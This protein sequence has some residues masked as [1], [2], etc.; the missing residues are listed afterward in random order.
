MPFPYV[1]SFYFSYNKSPGGGWSENIAMDATITTGAAAIVAANTLAA[2]RVKFLSQD[3]SLFQI[4]SR[5]IGPPRDAQ[6][7]ISPPGVGLVASDTV[8]PDL[9]IRITLIDAAVNTRMYDAHGVPAT[10]ITDSELN[11][12][13]TAAKST[14]YDPWGALVSASPW[15]IKLLKN[16]AAGILIAS[17]ITP[18]LGQQAVLTTAVPHGIA[19]KA[20]VQIRGYKSYPNRLMNGFWSVFPVSATT[21]QVIGSQTLDVNCPG[22]GTL[23]VTA[24]SSVV[25][26]AESVSDYIGS[27]K[28][29]RVFGQQRGRKSAGFLHH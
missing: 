17:I 14:A 10:W 2:Q 25:F 7:S 13:W 22:G 5:Q 1:S 12:T 20:N 15:A 29:G 24:P 3:C 28:V 8:V 27:R 6:Y 26:T 11:A 18:A 21:L 23:Y 16:P 9:F 4:V 19:G